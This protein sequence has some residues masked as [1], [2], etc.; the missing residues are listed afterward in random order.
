[1]SDNLSTALSVRSPDDIGKAKKNIVQKTPMEKTADIL[2][3][4]VRILL[5]AEIVLLF[6]PNFNPARICDKINKNMSLFTCGIAY[7]TLVSNL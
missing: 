1:M 5:I 7:D 6:F 3:W 4:G 2:L